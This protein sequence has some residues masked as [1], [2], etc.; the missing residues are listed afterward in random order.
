M[1]YR[2]QEEIKFPDWEFE[3]LKFLAMHPN[4]VFSKEQLFE[5]VWGYDYVGDS[6]A[7]FV[8]INRIRDKIEEDPT[9]PNIIWGPATG[10]IIRGIFLML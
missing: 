7:V 5:R 3:L 6:A 8:H 1:A 10:S 4:I 9:T 2:G